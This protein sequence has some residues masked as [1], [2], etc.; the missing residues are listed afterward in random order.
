MGGKQW[1]QWPPGVAG[2]AAWILGEAQAQPLGPKC[3][4]VP[5]ALGCMSRG[6]WDAQDHSLGYDHGWWGWSGPRDRGWQL[7]LWP[8][9][10]LGQRGLSK[11][12]RRSGCGGAEGSG[13]QDLILK[14]CGS[15]GCQMGGGRDGLMEECVLEDGLSPLTDG[16]RLGLS[17]RNCSH[18]AGLPPRGS[19]DGG[20]SAQT[21]LAPSCPVCG[22][23][24]A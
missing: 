22:I 19:E 17:L 24:S 20:G 2:S 21:G 8:L 1:G 11:V 3:F 6:A 10:N 18:G 5:E 16:Q 12:K 7:D 15:L 4:S 9:C 13:V 23:V 14:A